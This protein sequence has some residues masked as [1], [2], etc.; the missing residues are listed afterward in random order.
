MEELRNRIWPQVMLALTDKLSTTYGRDVGPA[1]F[2]VAVKLLRLE[3]SDPRLVRISDPDAW[4][5]V[6]LPE[7]IQRIV[8]HQDVTDCSRTIRVSNLGINALTETDLEAFRVESW[9]FVQNKFE[10]LTPDNR[11]HRG[12]SALAIQACGIAC[13]RLFV[14]IEEANSYTANTIGQEDY[15]FVGRAPVENHFFIQACS[16]Y[17]KTL[18]FRNEHRDVLANLRVQDWRSFLWNRFK[19]RYRDA[20]DLVEDADTYVESS[21]LEIGVEEPIGQG[22]Q[23]PGGE[24][25]TPGDF[26]G[27]T[28][29]SFLT[30]NSFNN[31][32][33]QMKD[34]ERHRTL[35]QITV[36]QLQ[37]TAYIDPDS[38]IDSSKELLKQS[39]R[40][41][42]K[43]YLEAQSLLDNCV[44]K[45]H[46]FSY[47]LDILTGS[48]NLAKRDADSSGFFEDREI[49][50]LVSVGR[51]YY[52]NQKIA[53]PDQRG[54]ISVLRN[55]RQGIMGDFR[56]T[57]NRRCLDS[58]NNLKPR[59]FDIAVRFQPV[60]A[61]E[62][63][64]ELNEFL[65]SFSFEEL[66]SQLKEDN[67]A[68]KVKL[69][70]FR[71]EES[72]N[73]YL[74]S[75]GP[76]MDSNLGRYKLFT[77]YLNALDQSL[78]EPPVREDVFWVRDQRNI[79]CI[80]K[81]NGLLEG[82]ALP[83]DYNWRVNCAGRH[84]PTVSRYLVKGKSIAQQ[85]AV[86]N[87]V[88]QGQL[89]WLKTDSIMGVAKECFKKF[90]CTAQ[91]YEWRESELSGYQIETSQQF[92]NIEWLVGEFPKKHFT[93]EI[94]T[95]EAVRLWADCKE[96]LA[97]IENLTVIANNLRAQ[98][99]Q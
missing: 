94:T 37:K 6:E 77:R 73:Q 84:Q 46:A 5:R 78:D 56:L 29:K 72:R 14:S 9:A 59:L 55:E 48:L 3:L 13:C 44:S 18:V 41:L 20:L 26:S 92:R 82:D 24:D 63:R 7:T 98:V 57:G 16:E 21:S 40:D 80:L 65:L 22:T 25:G 97:R 87:L 60:R 75:F 68:S 90:F 93:L 66:T 4:M 10:S 49:G 27:H 30:E 1:C 2:P 54:S 99:R 45:K 15:T 89:G 17:S 71:H 47:K 52:H 33:L 96:V 36:Y 70:A 61:L 53:T 58:V 86:Y 79:T 67:I 88:E 23:G 95:R 35:L 12:R 11:I 64:I 38:F 31:F 74:K 51:S 42:K 39:M 81:E 76:D 32:C 28:K 34:A 50:N 85:V 43:D 19:L 83:Y 91:K 62:E 8:E 69:A